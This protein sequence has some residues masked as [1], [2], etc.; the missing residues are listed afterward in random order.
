MAVL[1]ESIQLT[2]IVPVWD[3]YCDFLPGCV[4][5]LLGQR[6]P[7]RLLI[8]DN[9][10]DTALPTLP[11]GVEV[12]RTRSRL[13]AGAARN[14]ALR[15]VSTPYVCFLDVDDRLLPGTL[16]FCLERLREQPALIGCM[17]APLAWNADTGEIAPFAYPRP[18]VYWLSG[19][20][21]LLALYLLGR[22]AVNVAT[23]SVWTTDA[24]RQAGGFGDGDYAE[25]WQL[26][27]ALALR[28]AIALHRRPGRLY[29][30][31]DGSLVAGVHEDAYRRCFDAL[32]AQARQTPGSSLAVRASLPLFAVLHRLKLR[33]QVRSERRAVSQPRAGAM[34]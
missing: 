4:D 16:A 23:G 30:Q 27:S 15:R 20:R 32:R 26:A 7:L 1:D 9:C 6:V 17:T 34:A 24:V 19:R 28:G 31:H 12:I 25:D 18:H 8:V 29:R 2:A 3:R 11:A 10:S 21:T 22:C 14:H 33:V 13:S 5:D